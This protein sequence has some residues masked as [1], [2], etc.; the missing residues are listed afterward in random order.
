MS[1]SQDKEHTH[2]HRAMRER[3]PITALLPIMAAVLSAFLIIGLAVL[4][5]SWSALSPAA[6]SQPV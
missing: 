2:L 5:S 6:N 1:E 4:A 3:A